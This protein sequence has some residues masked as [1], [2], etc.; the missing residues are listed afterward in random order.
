[1]ES[2]VAL[3]KRIARIAVPALLG[4]AGGYAYYHF[5]GCSSGLCPITGNP[6]ASTAYGA[7]IGLIV[8][9]PREPKTPA[10]SDAPLAR[11]PRP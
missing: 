5:I 10:R 4:A 9:R 1:M 6:W 11:E 3:M 2:P 7:T 8:S